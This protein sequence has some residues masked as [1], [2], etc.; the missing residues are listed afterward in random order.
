VA[1]RGNYAGNVAGPPAQG[2]QGLSSG[3]ATGPPFAPVHLPIS[4]GVATRIAGASRP[5]SDRS[6]DRLTGRGRVRF[7]LLAAIVLL[8]CYWQPRIQAGD[9]SSHIYN[10]WL[11]QLI[12]SGRLPGLHFA[13]QF[14]NVLF[15]LLLAGLIRPL[16]PDGAQ[17]AAV[18]LAVLIFTSG[19]FAFASALAGRR[20]WDIAPCLGVLAYGW[21]FH[22]GFFNF[23]M[24]LGLG[25]WAL[26]LGWRF[27]PRRLTLAAAILL[28]AYTAHALPVL[29][30]AGLF[31]YVWFARK[32]RTGLRIRL[33]GAALA[34]L[35]AA[36]FLLHRLLPVEWSRDQL[37]L[38]TG[39]DQAW[40]F[41]HK[42]FYLATALLLL[43]GWQFFDLVRSR[44]ARD[45]VSGVP[46]QIALL[47]AASVCLIPDAILIPG[48]DHSLAF[49]AERMSLAAGVSM[50][51]LL[52]GARPSAPQ[53]YGY[54]VIALLFF[55]FL[56][57]DERAL[58]RLE[59]RIDALAAQLPAGTRVVS[60]ITDPSHR[61]NSVVHM[62]DRACLGRCFSYANYEPST[63][64]F[65][66]RATRGNSFVTA[67]YRDS[68]EMQN[69][70]HVR[71]P[72]EPPLVCVTWE[73]AGR[74]AAHEWR[75]GD[76][77]QGILWD[78]FQDR[79]AKP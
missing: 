13:S 48:Y 44:G 71:R 45:L 79:T 41:D 69:G 73:P 65:R 51:A 37:S 2:S 74:L 36:L 23:Y 33:L 39:A 58:N 21:V 52:A 11:A 59:D 22:M 42:Y 72:A 20:A 34:L 25:F 61:F 14:T 49:I 40:V 64:Q 38:A 19:A 6:W 29:W 78:V 63:A 46:F 56:F 17:R 27:D 50:C 47:A 35:A 70:E 18:T 5:V 32:L 7:A 53:K 68:W 3:A 26:A 55:V 24:A 8:P 60:P 76:F 15:D 66:V 67:N 10:A 12:E 16:G 62:I 9:L 75:S 54:M 4:R 31:A 1:G 30:T 57:H 28:L 77:C 43:W